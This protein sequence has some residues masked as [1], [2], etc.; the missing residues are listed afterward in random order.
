MKKLYNFLERYG[1][2]AKTFVLCLATMTVSMLNFKIGQAGY[3]IFNGI[4]AALWF[5]IWVLE[6][7]LKWEDK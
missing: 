4:L 3:G 5:I 1:S 2:I 7:S 6:L